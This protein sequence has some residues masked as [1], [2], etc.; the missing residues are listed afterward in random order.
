MITAAE[1]GAIA[2]TA[3]AEKNRRPMED[4]Y[5]CI[6]KAASNGNRNVIL[7]FDPFRV[8]KGNKTDT[9][10]LN[11][12]LLELQGG[13]FTIKTVLDDTGNKTVKVLW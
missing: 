8:I 9:D 2:D 11:A 13:G 5:K 10:R 4:A 3:I 12:F 1:A 7:N 6:E